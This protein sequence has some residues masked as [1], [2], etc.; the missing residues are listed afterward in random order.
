MSSFVM[1]LNLDNA[2]FHDDDG[3]FDPNPELS[4][5]LR[6]AAK[7]VEIGITARSLFDVN[8]NKVGKFVIEEYEDGT[9]SR[10]T[11]QGMA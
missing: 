11:Y 5:I 7:T 6:E 8:G 9:R 10:R 3:D 2:A 4:R 1:T